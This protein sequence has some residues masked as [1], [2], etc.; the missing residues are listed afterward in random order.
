MSNT[1]S[2]AALVNLN[3]LNAFCFQATVKDLESLK[4][5]YEQITKDLDEKLT[6]AMT[7]NEKEAIER[8]INDVNEKWE[9]MDEQVNQRQRIIAQLAP[10]AE[11]FSMKEQRFVSWLSETERRLKDVPDINQVTIEEYDQELKVGSWIW[12]CKY[13]PTVL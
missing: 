4:P 1:V 6:S 8:K 13:R 12:S 3:I 7:D 5:V 11:E 9:N 10:K 2:K